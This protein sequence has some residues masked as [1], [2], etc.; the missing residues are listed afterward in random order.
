V[1][2]FLA[3]AVQLH[4]GS[5][6]EAN[7]ALAATLTRQAAARGARLIVLP[8]LFF[9]GGPRD[10]ETEAAESIPG[11]TS[12]ALG[13]LARELDIFL[14]GGSILEKV[15]GREKVYNTCLSFDPSGELR[16]TYRK[17]HLFDVEVGGSVSV[18][19]SEYRDHGVDPIVAPCELT[20]LGLTVCY[21]LR[22]PELF[23]RLV[24]GGAKVICM[25]SAFTFATGSVHWEPLLR[26]RAIEN[27]VYVVAPN[28]HGRGASGILNYGNSMIVDPWGTVLAR[29]GDGDGIV[30]A[31]VDLG[32][33]ERVRRE[34]PCL[35]HRVIRG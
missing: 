35:Q 18:R 15:A 20:P 22:F 6:K 24:D 28:Q 17:I 34:I 13:A 11:P 33:L 26:A 14:V 4:V 12:E 9:W 30:L 1:D 32:Y 23:R 25:P 29:A 16:A 2:R 31:D 10:L 27:Q 21:D 8:E 7:F 5:D 19:E 3:A